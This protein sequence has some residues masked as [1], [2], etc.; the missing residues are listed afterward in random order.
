MT[1]PVFVADGVTNPLVFTVAMDG[2]LLVQ[3]LPF[4]G[5]TVQIA[6]APPVQRI[7]YPDENPIADIT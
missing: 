2:S 6:G 7:S 5:L 4:I 1:V 3:L